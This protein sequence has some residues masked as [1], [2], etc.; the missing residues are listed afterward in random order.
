MQRARRTR[1]GQRRAS[2]GHEPV[3]DRSLR[4]DPRRVEL[5]VGHI[6]VPLDMVEVDRV[7]E[8]WVLI[9]IAGVSPEDGVVNETAQVA[10]EMSMVDGIEADQRRE[11]TDIRLRQLPADEVAL[12]GEARLQPVEPGE[13]RV[14]RLLVSGLGGGKTG[15]VDPVVDLVEEDGLTASISSHRGSG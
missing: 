13:E 6:V 9:E 15:L 4:H 12:A 14:D 11:Q 10:F 7:P 8:A 2:V 1:S 3:N 5:R